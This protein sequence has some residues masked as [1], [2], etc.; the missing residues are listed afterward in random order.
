MKPLTDYK[1]F[2]KSREWNEMELLYMCNTVRTGVDNLPFKIVPAAN[3]EQNV[4]LVYEPDEL[5]LILTLPMKE[6]M[7]SWIESEYCNGEPYD[8]YFPWKMAV[9][10]DD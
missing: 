4:I 5:S 7:I 8:T 3:S 1:E 6:S 2:V 9:D 10:K